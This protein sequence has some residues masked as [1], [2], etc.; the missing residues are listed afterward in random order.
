MWLHCSPCSS[1]PDIKLHTV[2]CLLDARTLTATGV[3]IQVPLNTL[4]KAPLPSRWLTLRPSMAPML[5]TCA[6]LVYER[7]L[8]K[9]LHRLDVFL[10][11][12][13]SHW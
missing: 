6:L 7:A 4:P 3:P 11:A 9:L 13:G 5:S 8:P 12:W 2:R 1:M 10:D